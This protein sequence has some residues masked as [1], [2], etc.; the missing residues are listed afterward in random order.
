MK[1]LI[2][3]SSASN[4]ND[5]YVQRLSII[6]EGLKRL[7]VNTHILHLGDYFFTTPPLIQVL[8]AP[9][10]LKLTRGYDVIH[11][12]STVAT[13]CM[14][15]IK[16][17][18]N[19]KVVYDIHGNAIEEAHLF[20][21]NALDIK[22][23]YTL[24]QSMIMEPIATNLADYFITA[25]DALKQLYVDKGIDELQVEVIRC[26]VDIELFR[27]AESPVENETF[28][29]TYA[30]SF[31]VWQGIENL[32]HAA[33]L[34]KDER[35]NFKMIGFDPKELGLK[36]EIKRI[37]MNKVELI[38]AVPQ[39]TLVHYLNESDVLI[40]PRYCP[41]NQKSWNRLRN[42][43]GWSPTKFAEY[44]AT[45]RPVIVTTLDET[46]DFVEKYDCGFVCDPTPEAIARTII[47]AK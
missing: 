7:G 23:N 22:G 12:G 28:T 4:D 27:P 21:K 46:S 34:L 6:E 9:F 42:T 17:F 11:G 8:N 45:A 32:V 33:K 37:L 38:D 3:S 13:F 30:G 39:G 14:G 18:Y 25:S 41:A 16:T 15:L 26:G 19:S 29:V 43:F 40:I 35:V 44:I 31:R 1:V 36:P 2:V 47:K 24:F 10:F 5:A 20:R